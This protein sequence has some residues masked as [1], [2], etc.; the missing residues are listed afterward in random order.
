METKGRHLLLVVAD[1]ATREDLTSQLEQLDFAIVAAN[2]EDEA[3]ALLL[4]DEDEKT[5]TAPFCMILIGLGCQGMLRRIEADPTLSAIPTLMIAEENELDRVAQSLEHGAEDVLRLPF[6]AALWKARIGAYLDKKQLRLQEESTLALLRLEHDLEI[7]HQIQ[8]SFLPDQGN[9]PQA[10]GWEIAVCFRPARQVA[11]DFYDA[12]PLTGNKIGLIVADV[13]DKGVGAALFMAL[14]RSLLRAFAE[15]HRPLGWFDFSGDDFAAGMDKRDLVKRRRILLSAGASAL[16]A[17][18]LTNKYITDNHYEMNMFATTFFGVLDPATG[19]L[20][21]VNGGHDPP[22]II[23]QDGVIKQRL[24]P[25]G[26]AVGM[27]PDMGFDVEQCTLEP[28]DLLLAFTDGVSDARNPDRE[29]FGV[30]RLLRI[31]SEPIA[32]ASGLLHN[33]EER[34]YEH[35]GGASQY[36]DITMLAARRVPLS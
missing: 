4:C 15:Q 21:Y 2:G 18:Q 24:M 10:P 29:R 25:T 23:G 36:D 22:V 1:S 5:E 27:L 9:V 28:G 35:I 19:V 31:L 3:S 32:S 11:G 16:L 14:S 13:C 20:S 7:G 33:I 12:F 8:A 30:D 6:N 34:V 17:V 26:P